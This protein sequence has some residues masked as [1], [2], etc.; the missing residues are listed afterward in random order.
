MLLILVLVGA[1]GGACGGNGGEEETAASTTTRAPVT[2][3]MLTAVP[4]TVTTSTTATTAVGGPALTSGSTLD[5]RGLGPVRVGMTP[6]E[7]TAAAGVPI[8]VPPDA[9]SCSYASVEGGPEGVLFMVVDGR[10]AR[11]TSGGRER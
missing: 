6:A 3:T 1:V 4:T 5:L 8:V 10:I 11:S 2:T 7:A 9:A